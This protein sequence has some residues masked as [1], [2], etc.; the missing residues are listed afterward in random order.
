M[1]TIYNILL[2]NIYGLKSGAGRA[3]PLSAQDHPPKDA[4][5]K[6]IL[7]YVLRYE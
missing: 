3:F 6:Q 7:F 1:Y 5:T 4:K 2:Y